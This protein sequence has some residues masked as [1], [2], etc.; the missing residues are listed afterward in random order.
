[1]KYERK[2]M[3]GGRDN[4]YLCFYIP[5]DLADKYHMKKGQTVTITDN[6][7]IILTIKTKD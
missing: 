1:M 2:L 6:D 4:S 5:K 7:N 3:S